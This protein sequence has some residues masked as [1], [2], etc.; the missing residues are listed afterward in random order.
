MYTSE[1]DLIE[2]LSFG[3]YNTLAGPDFFNAQ[4]II[5]GQ[6]WAG[7]VE[8]HLKS[9]YWYAHH[10]EKDPSYHNVIL[11]VVWEHDIEVFDN[12]SQ[13]IPT[14]ELKSFIDKELINHYKSTLKAQYNFIPC[15]KSHHLVPDIVTITWNERLFV[16]R[17]EEK[18]VFIEM[19][20][21]NCNF[22]WEKTLFL[23]LLKSFGSTVNG[24]SF[25]SIGRNIDFSIIRKERTH[26]LHLEALLLGQAN[27]LMPN[28]EVHYQSELYSTYRYLKQKYN[29]TDTLIKVT[30]T[31][32][33]P[34]GFPTI[35][36]SQVAQLYEKSN[37]LFSNLMEA[38]SFT[39]AKELLGSSTSE[40]WQTHYTFQKTSKKTTKQLSNQLI[41]L[42]WINTV[43]P[44]KYLYFKTLGKDISEEL[45]TEMKKLSP[46]TNTIITQFKNLGV[47]I[48]SAFD[49]QVL[50]QQYK[51]YC[52]P[53]HCLDCA[54][55]ISLLRN[56]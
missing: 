10:H 20:Y 45:M 5:G 1:G 54:I 24:E 22:D 2:I 32:L 37:V 21:N 23:M 11:H 46:E 13:P 36:L 40:F 33:R 9:S 41:E 26:P 27:L 8:M 28:S 16:E 52:T 39:E 25:I 34:Q 29:L 12:N 7:S 50:L 3:T 30:F 44:L 38:T 49:S 31:G 4:I 35:R 42:L 53:K 18:A 15:E 6:K 47:K 51:H 55:G 14:L 48:D 17:L 19:L 43:V 56:N